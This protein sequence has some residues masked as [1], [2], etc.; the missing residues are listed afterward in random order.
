MEGS[1]LKGHAWLVRPMHMPAGA[2]L[3]AGVIPLRWR[4][5]LLAAPGGTSWWG[6]GCGT[7][8][9]QHW[10]T[11]ARTSLK[12]GIVSALLQGPWA[13]QGLQLGWPGLGWAD[14]MQERYFPQ[15]ELA[16]KA[17]IAAAADLALAVLFACAA[18]C[19]HGRAS[20]GAVLHFY[21]D[22]CL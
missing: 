4:G 17:F 8:A 15:Q 22:V 14:N 21:E 19:T 5:P 1:E 7:G 11:A 16:V 12:V 9:A 18:F 3:Q 13:W 10:C 20:L 6:Q 2:T